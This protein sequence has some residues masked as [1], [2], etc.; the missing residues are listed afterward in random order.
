MTLKWTKHLVKRDRV[1]TSGDIRVSQGAVTS[2]RWKI[3]WNVHEGGL[4]IAGN[5]TYLDVTSGYID[6]YLQKNSLSRTLKI[7][8]RSGA[9]ELT[10]IIEQ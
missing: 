7:T 6:T 2:G 9:Q 4:W 3:E 5:V 10:S 1:L 8:S